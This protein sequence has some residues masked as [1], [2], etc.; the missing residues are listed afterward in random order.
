[1]EVWHAGK[2]TK[3]TITTMATLAT[4]TTMTTIRMTTQ[5]AGETYMNRTSLPRYAVGDVY[6]TGEHKDK[7]KEK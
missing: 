6:C 3:S 4:M 5:S 7:N 1:M 2:T